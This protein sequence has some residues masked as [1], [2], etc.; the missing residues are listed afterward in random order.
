[1]LEPL[2]P[3]VTALDPAPYR[4]LLLDRRRGGKILDE[5]SLV[6]V[7]RHGPAY[8]LSWEA[9]GPVPRRERVLLIPSDAGVL[10]FSL[11]SSPEKFDAGRQ[12][13][14]FLLRT[15]RATGADGRLEMPLL[16]NRL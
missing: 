3:G 12:A 15:F 16:S 13:F 4:S 8:D 1:V 7:S 10:E 5:F 6:A 9:P 11:V 14:S 2:P